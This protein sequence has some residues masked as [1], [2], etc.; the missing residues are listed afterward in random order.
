MNVL[1]S[2]QENRRYINIEKVDNIAIIWMDDN[3]SKVNKISFELIEQ[4]EKIFNELTNDA[5]VDAM[6]LISKKKDFIA[7]LKALKAKQ[8]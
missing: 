8:G 6:I 5:S 4:Y 7:A 3:L 2:E 1:N